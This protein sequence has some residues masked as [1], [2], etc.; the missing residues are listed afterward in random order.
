MNS[1]NWFEFFGE[2]KEY[3]DKNKKI[4]SNNRVDK[5]IGGFVTRARQAYKANKLTE[6][7]IILLESLE[8]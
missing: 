7:K 5:K 6:E 2:L 8:N 3:S 1:E 4:P